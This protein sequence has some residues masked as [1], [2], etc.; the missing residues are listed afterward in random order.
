MSNPFLAEVRLMSFGFAPR[1]WALANGQLLP[2]NQNQALFALLGT[3]YGGNGQTNF[4]LP[5]LQG[6]VP[7]HFGGGIF[8]GQA[9]GE[10]YHTLLANEM[11]QHFHSLTATTAAAVAGTG[12]AGAL[13]AVAPHAP[14]RS[15]AVQPVALKPGVIQNAGGSQPHLNMQPSLAINFCIALTGI[16]PSRP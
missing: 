13:P 4:S 1:G 3:T 15:G 10:E 16:F 11:P 14:Y 2:I 6:R 7:L 9:G 8:L 12:P 5:N